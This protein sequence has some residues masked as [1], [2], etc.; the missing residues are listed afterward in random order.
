MLGGQRNQ[1]TS[2]SENRAQQ[3]KTSLACERSVSIS[4][5]ELVILAQSSDFERLTSNLLFG[6][7]P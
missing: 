6:Q 5:M 2:D 7:A 1:A 4:S 3:Q